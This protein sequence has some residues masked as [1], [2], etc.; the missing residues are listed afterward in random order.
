[1]VDLATYREQS[2][3]TWDGMAEGWKARRDWM[4]QVMGR[5]NDRLIEKADPQPGQ[6]FLDVAARWSRSP[7]AMAQSSA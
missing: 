1:M 7:A 3:E 5:V 6:V 2:L 4:S